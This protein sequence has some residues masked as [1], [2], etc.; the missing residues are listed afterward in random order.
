MTILRDICINADI[1]NKIN[2]IIRIQPMAKATKIQDSVQLLC[3]MF[4]DCGIPKI[5]PE[6]FRQAKFDKS[7]ACECLW[8]FLF[9][10]VTLLEHI[11]CDNIPESY[12]HNKGNTRPILCLAKVKM[13]L[14]NLGYTRTEFYNATY[15][16]SSRE[17]LLAFG[18]LLNEVQLLTMMRAYHLKQAHVQGVDLS[19]GYHLVLS[20]L[21]DEILCMEEECIDIDSRLKCG[22]QISDGIQKL[23]WLNGRMCMLYRQLSETYSSLVKLMHKLN[24]H[25]YCETRGT[26]VSLYGCYLVMHPHELSRQ[27]KKLEHHSMA[28]QSII[29]WQ[30]HDKIFWKWMESV[31]DAH[32]KAKTTSKEKDRIKNKLLPSIDSLR[33]E[34]NN[35]YKHLLQLL[36]EKESQMKSLDQV[37]E[38]KSVQINAIELK[39][40]MHRIDSELKSSTVYYQV[41]KHQTPV[42][43]KISPVIIN[44]LL[45]EFVYEPTV[46]KSHKT[47]EQVS[48]ISAIASEIR[49]LKQ[50]IADTDEKLSSLRTEIQMDFDKLITGRKLAAF[51]V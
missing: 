44:K 24:R 13:F 30:Q 23:T 15:L 34:V 31:T 10:V 51:C 33:D 37:W 20:L 1:S 35:L 50:S 36:N 11:S 26:F 25:S 6:I 21:Q 39:K 12:L 46:S 5:S 19:T 27:L 17:L 2:Q 22:N 14:H 3:K 32:E 48:Q 7:E 38:S 49:K 43:Y 45:P 29:E 9:H 42:F 28:L 18:W 47:L 40:E 8:Q 4:S 16:S 41:L